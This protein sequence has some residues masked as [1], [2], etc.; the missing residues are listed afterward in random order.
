[1]S[2]ELLNGP[3]VTYKIH[4]T[5]CVQ[6]ILPWSPVPGCCHGPQQ[7]QTPHTQCAL[8]LGWTGTSGPAQARLTDQSS[9]N[10]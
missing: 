9:P 6:T 2:I 10:L 4:C 8:L 1:L 3:L 5:S 7:T